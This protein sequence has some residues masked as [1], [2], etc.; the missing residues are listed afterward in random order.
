MKNMGI[1]AVALIIGANCFIE[2]RSDKSI[3]AAASIYIKSKS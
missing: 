2:S 3:G 1:F